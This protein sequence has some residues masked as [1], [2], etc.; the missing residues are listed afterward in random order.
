MHQKVLANLRFLPK[1]A[2]ASEIHEITFPI[3]VPLTSTRRALSTL[4][5]QGEAI[6]TDQQKDGPFGRP[7]Y[8]Y[9]A[10]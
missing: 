10:V 3:E 9:K 7:E 8:I 5:E 4:V 1:G 6:K 2:T